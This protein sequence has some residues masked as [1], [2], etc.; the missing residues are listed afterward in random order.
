M[1]TRL[2]PLLAAAAL[3]LLPAVHARGQGV[4]KIQG[5][6]RRAST[7]YQTNTLVARSGGAKLY[8]VSGYNF[9]G[10]DQYIFILNTNVV[11]ANGTFASSVPPILVPAGANFSY[12]EDNGLVMSTGITVISSTTA[13]TLTKGAADCTFLCTWRDGAN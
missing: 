5:A 7:T 8:S 12:T 2:V 13:A 3:L 9:A 10:V 11:P 6:D 4:V 1:K